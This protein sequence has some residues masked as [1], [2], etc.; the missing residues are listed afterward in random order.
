MRVTRAAKRR[1]AES[2]ADPPPPAA[3]K[4][5]VLGEISSNVLGSSNL[6]DPS[7]EPSKSARGRRRKSKKPEVPTPATGKTPAEDVVGTANAVAED[8]DAGTDD[9]QIC[10]PYVAGIYEYLRNMEVRLSEFVLLLFWVL[11]YCKSK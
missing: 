2:T 4:R 6:N 8:I 10:G 3:K 5:V 1:A 9:P 11:C 7:S